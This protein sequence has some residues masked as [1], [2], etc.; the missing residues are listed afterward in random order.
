M[1]SLTMH[2]RNTSPNQCLFTF[3][4]CKRCQSFYEW[5]K[6]GIT[7]NSIRNVTSLIFCHKTKHKARLLL[8]LWVIFVLSE[9]CTEGL[10]IAKKFFQK[11]ICAVCNGAIWIKVPMWAKKWSI[12]RN[13]TNFTLK[14]NILGLLY[15]EWWLNFKVDSSQR[16]M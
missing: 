10:W 12:M 14:L 6:I 1:H 3:T 16:K 8:I 2:T 15:E 11:E 4:I 5:T 9:C 13:Y 7:Q